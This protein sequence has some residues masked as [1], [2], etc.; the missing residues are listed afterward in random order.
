MRDINILWYTL[1]WAGVYAATAYTTRD[2]ILS[3][4]I[5]ATAFTFLVIVH[6]LHGFY[7]NSMHDA[8]HIDTMQEYVIAFYLYDSIYILLF[9][10]Q[11]LS[12]VAHHLAAIWITYRNICGTVDT[13]ALVNYVF[14]IEISNMF[15]NMYSYYQYKKRYDTSRSLLIGVVLT[16]VPLRTVGMAITTYYMMVD[17]FYKNNELVLTFLYLAL[18][19]MSFMYSVKFMKRLRALSHDSSTSYANVAARLMFK[20]DERTFPVVVLI[21]KMY[22]NMYLLAVDVPLL[23]ICRW[24]MVCMSCVD[25]LKIFSSWVFNITNFDATT[26]II[27][28]LMIHLKITTASVLSLYYY[29]FEESMMIN[30]VVR[31]SMYMQYGALSAVVYNIARHKIRPSNNKK[32]CTRLLLINY[33]ASITPQLV[34]SKNNYVWYALLNQVLGAIVWYLG[35]PESKMTSV[36][37]M[38]SVGWVHLFVLFGDWYYS[39]HMTT[40]QNLCYNLNCGSE[41]S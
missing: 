13:D 36:R 39:K 7:T 21:A 28:Y 5:T 4:Y 29:S 30:D 23:P 38:N 6:G 34:L 37:I 3:S 10:R 16:Y 24:P 12:F 2:S 35:I 32:C 22:V 40:L 26:E 8:N 9:A 33:I 41:S 11:W 27:D 17:N 31:V 25:V 20:P 19:C 15:I 18:L 1:S 14:F